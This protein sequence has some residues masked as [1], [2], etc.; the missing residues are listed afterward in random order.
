[1][2]HPP[3]HRP[4]SA[5][6]GLAL[7]ALLA[8]ACSET[9][10]GRARRHGK[11]RVVATV[12]MLADAA[13]AIGGDRVLVHALMGPGIDPH[14]FKASDADIGRLVDAD[15]I[16]YVGLHL[17]GKMTRV[18]ERMRRYK[19]TLAIGETLAPERLRTA[20]GFAGTYDP[21]IWFD[22]AL[23]ADALVALRDEL[24]ERDPAGA[25]HY[26]ARWRRY[27]A[28]L[29]ALDRWVRARIAEIPARRRVLITAHD[30]FGYFGRAYG[31]EVR[32][33]QGLS[34]VS[35]AGLRDL[36]RLLDLIVARR[37]GAVFVESSV[38]RRGIEALIAG[39]RAR[40]HSLRIGGTL[41]SDALGP[42]GSGAETYIGM[43]RHN[44]NAIVE[45]LK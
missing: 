16:V 12:G 35:E 9:P 23:W 45:A 31:I 41:Y 33:L 29:R 43:V 21:H 38:S 42:P 14:L 4:A 40:G 19:P 24:I 32:G 15:A 7:L 25:A 37:I 20:P 6:L 27:D 11:L 28:E 18:F 26:R 13:R 8:G 30:A 10:S 2:A 39:A 5:L 44:V 36:A 1:M 3:R 17:E 22:V 34:T